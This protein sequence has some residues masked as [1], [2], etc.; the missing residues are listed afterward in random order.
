MI[1]FAPLKK[2]KTNSDDEKTFI[3]FDFIIVL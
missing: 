2:V 1:I 3:S